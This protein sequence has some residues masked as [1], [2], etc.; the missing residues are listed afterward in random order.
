M[1]YRAAGITV[2][3]F[4]LAMAMGAVGCG[5][6]SAPVPPEQARPARIL[7]LRASAATGGIKLTWQ[8]P[9]HYSG[10]R[11]MRDLNDFVIMRAAD[12]GPMAPL[13]EIP[14]T[15][16]QR[17]QIEREFTYLDS[18]TK[19]GER[20]RYT[21]I[22]ETRDGYRSLPSNEVEFSR[23]TPPPPPSPE[24]FSLPTPSPLPTN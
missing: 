5:I 24:N 19:M 20:Y 22:A 6:K 4:A 8:R 2:L 3:A 21:V 1:K 23:I 17:F 15:D 16:Q 10:G 18:E 14:I 9:T 11:A 13:I 7:D 12:D